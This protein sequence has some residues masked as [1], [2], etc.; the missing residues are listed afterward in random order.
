VYTSDHVM[1]KSCHLMSWTSHAF[2]SSTKGKHGSKLQH[3]KQQRKK[4]Q[5][6][7]HQRQNQRHTAT[8]QAPTAAPDAGD[9]GAAL[10]RAR[11]SGVF[12]PIPLGVLLLPAFG[13]T[14]PVLIPPT[15]GL[16]PAAVAHAANDTPDPRVTDVTLRC[17]YT[18]AH[19]S[20]PRCETSHDGRP[21]TEQLPTFGR[22]AS[23]A[24]SAPVPPRATRS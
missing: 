10:A 1:H 17:K 14:P 13:V 15:H 19:I 20:R 11:S 12:P 4:L 21:P 16:L 2:T 24:A 22:A 3:I 7:V 18:R 23:G 9:F 6:I 5:H 8:R